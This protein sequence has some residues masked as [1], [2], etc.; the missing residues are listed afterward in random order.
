MLWMM[1]QQSEGW[2]PFRKL[3]SVSQ[4]KAEL[5]D[6]AGNS[7]F[8]F[9][10]RSLMPC[11]YNLVWKVVISPFSLGA[12]R[13]V[14]AVTQMLLLLYSALVAPSRGCWLAKHQ[15]ALLP[16]LAGLRAGLR[17]LVGSPSA[18]SPLSLCA[19]VN[20]DLINAGTLAQVPFSRL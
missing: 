17:E 5:H 15:S 1:D 2:D 12:L 13:S 3:L 10:C 20:E 4:I 16:S 11:C 8:L 19:G 14:Q 18:S 9:C 6:L 7:V